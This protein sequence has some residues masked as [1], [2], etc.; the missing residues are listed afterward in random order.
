MRLRLYRALAVVSLA[1]L[2]CV[3]FASGCRH[4]QFECGVAASSDS[5]KAK[6][7]NETGE[8]CICST[9]RCAEPVSKNECESEFRYVFGPQEDEKGECVELGDERPR[10]P[11]GV[12]GDSAFC[13][14]EGPRQAGC[15]RPGTTACLSTEVCICSTERCAVVE[16]EA[17]DRYRYVDTGE[18]VEPVRD[19]LILYPSEFS[20][21]DDG[22][23]THGHCPQ[24]APPRPQCGT[25]RGADGIT[26]CEEGEVCICLNG[27]RRCAFPL[28]NS[29]DCESGYAWSSADHPCVEQFSAEEIEGEEN[30]LTEEGICADPQDTT[31]DAG[32]D[33]GAQD[34]GD[35]GGPNG[36]TG[37]IQIPLDPDAADA[38]S[39]DALDVGGD[40]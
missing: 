37:T 27:I 26:S 1:V 22:D 17:C 23:G 2:F 19:D 4:D 18:C 15:G 34:A 14:G 32:L 33:G 25:S 36:D 13:P 21:E 35:A 10:I 20:G 12:T 29:Y 40:L 16:T 11:E 24:Y 3:L 28:H 5:Q 8:T 31:A 7:C 38:D 39:T 9:N 6:R 30:A